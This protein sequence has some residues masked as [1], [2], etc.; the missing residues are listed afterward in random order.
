MNINITEIVIA[1][2]ITTGIG[3]V[4]K[5]VLDSVKSSINN[6]LED[7][8]NERAKLNKEIEL[9]KSTVTS[10]SEI[11]IYY[12]YKHN[13][14]TNN[15]RESLIEAINNYL[16]FN[17]NDRMLKLK[18]KILNDMYSKKGRKRNEKSE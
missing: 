15:E 4:I 12:I 18:E 16:E 17:K 2:I 5:L 8:N 1:G 7:H 13:N 3:W 6:I 11:M 9:L 10:L 14:L